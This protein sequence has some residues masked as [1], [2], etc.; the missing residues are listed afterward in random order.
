M[1]WRSK[2]QYIDAR[3]GAETEFRAMAIRMSELLWLKIILDELKITRSGLITSFYDKKSAT[4]IAHN[5]VQ[6]NWTNDVEIDRHFIREA[7]STIDLYPVHVIRNQ[8][9]DNGLASR[10]LR[11]I[12]TQ[13]EN[14]R[15]SLT[16][17]RG[18]V[19]NP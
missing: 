3:L 16:S 5:P 7:R 4:D 17:L 6:H 8:V 1:S 18:S 10:K 15:H 9:V 14:E 11:E 19:R 12:S 2:K 13:V